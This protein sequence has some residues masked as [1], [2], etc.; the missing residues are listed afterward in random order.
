MRISFEIWKFVLRE[1][2]RVIQGMA[3]GRICVEGVKKWPI[4]W[5]SPG[6]F[7]GGHEKRQRKLLGIL[8]GKNT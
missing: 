1:Y 8:P 3:V 4:S 6:N 7:Q 2:V 5:A